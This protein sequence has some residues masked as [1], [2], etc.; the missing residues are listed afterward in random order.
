MTVPHLM[1]PN[2]FLCQAEVIYIQSTFFH[3]I[4]DR[5]RRDSRI[6]V[7]PAVLSLLHENQIAA[8]RQRNLSISCILYDKEPLKPS[9][10]IEESV[11]VI[12][13]KSESKVVD[14]APKP[15]M[16]L[17]D[18]VK[19]EALH[20]YHGFRLLFIDINISRKLLWRVLNG[21]TLSRREH[22]LLVRTVGDLF[23]LLPFSVFI[24][25]PFMELLL[26][27]A[28]KMF[29]GMLPS[30]FQSATE[31]EDKLKQSLK[32]RLEMAKFLQTTL[33]DMSVQSKDKSGQKTKEFTEFF[34]RIRSSGEAPSNE[35]IIKFSTHFEDEIILDSLSR[36]QLTALCRVLDINPVGTTNLL[37]FQI[38]MRLRTLAADDKVILP[39]TVA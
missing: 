39:H 29:P 10:K 22:R 37:R 38:R 14:M 27:F 23:R 20:Y 31:K 4:P 11:K 21:K 3:T 9:S 1:T 7:S 24:I 5:W 25:V 30:T 33:D 36:Q 34:K 26:P 17:W 35:E 6:G 32:V 18:K 12:K 16:K 19:H 8:V 15:K 2:K 28:I 13:E